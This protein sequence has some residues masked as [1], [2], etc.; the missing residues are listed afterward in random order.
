M[1]DIEFIAYRQA[2]RR[3]TDKTR[4]DYYLYGGRGIQFKFGSFQEFV[5]VLGPKQPGYWLCRKDNN[6]HFEPGNVYWG[7][8]E[9]DSKVKCA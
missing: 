4:S 7:A 5:E 3:C 9:Q 6:G 2:M 1:P 8:R